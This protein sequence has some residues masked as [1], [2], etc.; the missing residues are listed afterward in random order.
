MKESQSNTKVKPKVKKLGFRPCAYCKKPMA[1]R[2]MLKTYCGRLCQD[3]AKAR[4]KLIVRLTG[5]GE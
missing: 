3:R 1:C 4:R 2:S 5:Y